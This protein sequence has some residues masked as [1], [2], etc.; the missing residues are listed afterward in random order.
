MQNKKLVR[1][2]LLVFAFILLSINDCF[3]FSIADRHFLYRK[4]MLPVYAYCFTLGTIIFIG[5]L[6]TCKIWETMTQETIDRLSK[7]LLNHPIP[8]IIFLGS[9]FAIP[10]GIITV[11]LWDYSG[12]ISDYLFWGVIISLPV[13]LMIRRI[14]EKMLLSP[15]WIKWELMFALSSVMSTLL[16]IIF[17]RFNF[18]PFSN[19]ASLILRY[20]DFHYVLQYIQ[21]IWFFPFI[22]ISEIEITLIIYCLIRYLARLLLKKMKSNDANDE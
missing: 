6:I 16:F 13:L 4:I 5:L 8:A 10:L 22:F 7:Y 19:M 15:L 12:V 14:R 17:S 11:I 18:L 9:L 20:D 21:R 3:G 2:F 1:V